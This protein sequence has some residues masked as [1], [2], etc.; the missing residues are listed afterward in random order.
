MSGKPAYYWDTCVF[1]SLISGEKRSDPRE[2]SGILEH[3][4]RFDTGEIRLVTSV[5]TLTEV[6]TSHFT[7][8]ME[9]RFQG[10][11]HR[12]NFELINVTSIIATMAQ[13]LRG[14]YQLKA[15]SDGLPTLGTPDAIHVATAIV[16][17]CDV[18]FTFDG[19]DKPGKQRALLPLS[20]KIAGRYDLKIERPLSTQLSLGL[21]VQARKRSRLR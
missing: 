7:P 8:Q 10:I 2:S 16:S 9:E 4:S 12:S 13:E 15:S 20:P 21:P 11:T 1:I 3:V 18:L 6:L 19:S 14:F 5:L 17:H